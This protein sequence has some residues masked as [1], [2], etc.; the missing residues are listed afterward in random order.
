MGEYLSP[1]F[2]AALLCAAPDPILLV[3]V[4][5][6]IVIAS[7]AVERV[8]GYRSEELVGQPIEMLLPAA[9][10]DAHVARRTAYTAAPT[11]RPMGERMD[12]VGLRRDG[13]T[14]PLDISLS[15]VTLDE[16]YIICVARDAT[17][18][19]ALEAEL[20][21]LSFRDPVTGLY[22]RLYLDVEIERL[23]A[24]RQFP[25]SCFVFDVDFLKEV[26][27]EHGH[28]AGD[29]HLRRAADLLRSC[30]RSEDLVART[31]GDEFVAVVPRMDEAIA[32]VTEAR[33]RA[34]L[35]PPA[36]A[37]LAVRMS[38]GRATGNAP[39]IRELIASAD[40]RMYEAK[41]ARGSRRTTRNPL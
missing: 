5:G 1:E 17:A 41:R 40:H 10:R 20:R 28:A 3:G 30:F 19:R 8:F 35:Q 7:D 15:P 21:A 11:T 26:N 37:T 14:I 32:Q 22:S 12:L 29:Q 4:D 13:T 31:G 34:T 33:L 25:V 38:F 36:G 18:R 2:Y 27:D 24:S 23:D 9:V 6:R 16:R 39:P